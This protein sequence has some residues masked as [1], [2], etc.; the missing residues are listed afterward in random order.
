MACNIAP[1]MFWS[2][3]C[4]PKGYHLLWCVMRLL[5]TGRRLLGT[6]LSGFIGEK[7][8]RTCS[9]R[10]T[11]TA[12]RDILSLPNS[13][14]CEAGSIKK[15]CISVIRSASS[16]LAAS[17]VRARANVISAARASVP[18]SSLR[19]VI[20]DIGRQNAQSTNTP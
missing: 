20:L 3:V 16:C 17:M 4:F 6:N 18:R 15:L 9:H 11:A 14:M 12:I 7:I 8:E 13:G 19:L 10:R 1:E 2:N 5:Q